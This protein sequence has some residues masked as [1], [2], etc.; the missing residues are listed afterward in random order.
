M[1][2]I[3]IIIFPLLMILSLILP[4]I[5]FCSEQETIKPGLGNPYVHQLSENVLAITGL[6]HTAIEKGFTTNAGIIFTSESVI[7]ID[8]GQTIASAK[9]LWETARA[10]MKGYKKI[11]LILTHHHSDHVF[12]MRIFK[13]K[14][15]EI[16]AH[17]EVVDELQG[18][19]GFYKKFIA[20]KMGWDSEQAD[21]ILGDVILYQPDRTIEQD[22]VLHIDGDEIHLLVTPGHVPDEIS[23]YHSSSKTL[24]AGDTI[25][26]GTALATQFGG[27]E[28]WKTWISQLERLKELDILNIVPG[29]GEICSKDEI[30]RNINFLKEKLGNQFM[31]GKAYDVTSDKQSEA[32][33]G[34]ALI[35]G[36]QLFK[37]IVDKEKFTLIDCRPPEEYE[38]GHIPGAL[39]VSIDSFEFD[40][41]TRV[42]AELEKII[43]S[44]NEKI[45]FV[46]I[47][48]LSGEE[49][50]SK[51]KMEELLNYLP[52]NKNEEVIFYCRRTDCTRSPLAARWAVTLGYKNVFRFQ[53]GWQ[54]WQKR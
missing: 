28:E 24:F 37:K 1:K 36:Q 46:L 48:R 35:S 33:C 23:V 8:S 12:G 40:Q 52:Q 18:D 10:H 22:T 32:Q 49:Y 34:Y 47:D 17:K 26:E 5:L 14:G 38:A 42:K 45:D 50:M 13:D 54:E 31:H 19:N 16:I 6:Y 41:N 9:F 11:Y 3:H 21:E 44:Q 51:T 43:K 25:Y 2:K 4:C 20:D 30:D 15:A 53:G 29:H 39:N 7:F 27:A